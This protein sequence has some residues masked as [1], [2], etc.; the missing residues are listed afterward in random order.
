MQRYIITE[1][2]GL[3]GLKLE[4]DAEIPKLKNA[5]D[6]RVESSLQIKHH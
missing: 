5:T 6:V 4:S 2:K 3:D 1:Q